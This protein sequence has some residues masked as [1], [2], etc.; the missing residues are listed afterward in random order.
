MRF[1]LHQLSYLRLNDLND[2]RIQSKHIDTDK[3]VFTIIWQVNGND[4]KVNYA[5]CPMIQLNELNKE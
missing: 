5:C 3:D 4:I 2:D 1:Q